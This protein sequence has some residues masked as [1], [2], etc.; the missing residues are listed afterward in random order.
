MLLSSTCSVEYFS[1][2][3]N[4]KR[5]SFVGAGSC[6]SII[7]KCQPR[8]LDIVMTTMAA[9]VGGQENEEVIQATTAS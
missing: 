3:V 9:G 1:L 5:L 2:I 6:L 4:W 7:C 8:K